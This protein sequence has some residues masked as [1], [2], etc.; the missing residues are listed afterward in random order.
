MSWSEAKVKLGFLQSPASSP[1]ISSA[2]RMEE[3]EDE[4]VFV[5]EGGATDEMK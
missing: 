3:E 1:Q 4:E 2:P 5:F